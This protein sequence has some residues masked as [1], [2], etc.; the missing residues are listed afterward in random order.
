MS[1]DKRIIENCS[2]RYLYAVIALLSLAFMIW[3]ADDT[4]LWYDEFAQICYSGQNMTLLDSARVLDPTPPL[5][6]LLANLWYHIVPYGQRWLLLLPQGAV[7]FAVY[8]TGLW[9]EEL[10]GKKIGLIAASLLGSSQMVIEQCGFE[11][12]SYGI[13]LLFAVLALYLQTIQSKR[14][15]R[16]WYDNVFY[17]AALIGLLY[18]HPFGAIMTA[19]IGI[20]DIWRIVRYRLQPDILISY[21]VAGTVYLLWLI[22][23]LLFQG[24]LVA[25]ATEEWMVRPTPWEVLKLGA[26]LCSNHFLLCLLFAGGI[27]K[28]LILWKKKSREH[29]RLLL[30]IWVGLFMVAVVYCYGAIRSEHASLWARRYFCGLLPCA[31]VLSAFGAQWF[32]AELAKKT[33]VQ[34]SLICF[35]VLLAIVPYT[36]YRTAAMDTPLKTYYHRE[37]AEWLLQQPD[38]R[39]E[40]V[41]VF[42]TLG[43]T[44]EGWL[45]YYVTQKGGRQGFHAESLYDVSGEELLK[46]NVVYVDEGFSGFPAK[47]EYALILLE[48]FFHK[49]DAWPEL[50][51]VRYERNR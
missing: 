8:L 34:E 45:E 46:Y 43:Y 9:G 11:F 5:F 38:I 47:T 13:Y 32:A 41:V 2:G 35:V 44:T 16:D 27:L 30:V 40:N 4:S 42:S 18:S 31:A 28:A 25:V 36:L 1:F 6:N 10:G 48:S 49:S 12:R 39:D 15:K 17:T 14:E 7:A 33:H 50:E 24:A 21:I 51:L 19:A 23:Y 37:V 22:R 26:Y 29:E 3:H 20:H